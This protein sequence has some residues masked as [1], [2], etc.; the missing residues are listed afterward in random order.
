MRKSYRNDDLG[1][2]ACHGSDLR[3]TV[4]SCPAEDRT[5]RGK[6][7]WQPSHLRRRIAGR[8]D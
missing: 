1:C 2:G 6:D 5:V 4:L 3:S 7:N 8:G